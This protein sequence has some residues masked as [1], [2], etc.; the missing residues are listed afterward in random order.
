MNLRKTFLEQTPFLFGMPAVVWQ[1][2]FVYLPFFFILLLSFRNGNFEYF[3]PFFQGVYFWVIVRSLA[4]GLGTAL[5]CL[6]IAFPI[7][8]WIALCS[9]AWKNRLLFLLFIPFWTNFLLHIYAWMF[10]MDRHGI[11]NTVLQWLGI[12]HEPFHLLYTTTAV[13]VVMVYCYTPFMVLP[14]YTALEKFDVR[15]HEASLD[16]GATWWQTL[17]RIVVPLSMP[18]IRSGFFLVLVPA[19][20]EFVIPELI[21]GDKVMF[22]GSVVAYHTLHAK[23]ASAGAA[24]TILISLV[25][26]VVM[27][28]VSL[29]MKKFGKGK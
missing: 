6:I 19:F 3:T 5:L 24:F 1:G 4:L 15:L 7:A 20:G 8:Y 23:T 21:G 14:I 13:F 28:L 10:V 16:L 29:A 22:A 2:L 12:I 18:G 11:I 25:L 17:W 26:V 9:G 27:G